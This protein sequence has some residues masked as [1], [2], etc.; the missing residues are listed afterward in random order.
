M[1]RFLGNKNTMEVHDTFNEKKQCQ[2]NEIKPDHKKELASLSQ[3]HSEG[4]DNCDWCIGN[5]K[6]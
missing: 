5:S 2:L 4:F 1:T 3:A 6:R